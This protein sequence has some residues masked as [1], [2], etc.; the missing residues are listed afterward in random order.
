M[1]VCVVVCV[2]AVCVVGGESR[3]RVRT[4]LAVL[5]LAFDA[6]HI[7]SA[8]SAMSARRVCLS[9]CLPSHPPVPLDID[10][11]DLQIPCR[12]RWSSARALLARQSPLARGSRKARSRTWKEAASLQCCSATATAN[13]SVS[14][15][16][17]SS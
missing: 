16:Q 10:K 6:I 5:H 15:R 4:C 14:G 3:A 8:M 12:G 17:G 13:Q 2:Y 11:R 9:A 7:F 1:S